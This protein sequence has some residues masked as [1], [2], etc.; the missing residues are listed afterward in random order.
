M[1]GGRRS[2]SRGQLHVRVRGVV[3]GVGFRW[4]VRERARRLGLSGW[5]RNLP[6]GSVEVM[7]AGDPAQIDLLR[8]ELL[9]GPSGASV[10]ALEEV[11]TQPAEPLTQPFGILR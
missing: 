11:P 5:V 1:A 7:A 9:R 3:Q 10:E 6:D 8:G 2:V 4:F